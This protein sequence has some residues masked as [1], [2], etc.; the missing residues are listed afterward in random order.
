MSLIQLPSA[1]YERHFRRRELKV[2]IALQFTLLYLSM[3]VAGM[4]GR[5]L[6]PLQHAGVA[7]LD[8]RHATYSRRILRAM[9]DQEQQQEQQP[10]RE[11]SAGEQE[12]MQ[13]HVWHMQR[14]QPFAGQSHDIDHDSSLQDSLQ[15]YFDSWTTWEKRSYLD[16]KSSDLS[17]SG[18]FDS[19]GDF[20]NSLCL[21]LG[22]CRSSV[23]KEVAAGAEESVESAVRRAE[24]GIE[25]DLGSGANTN[26]N[27][28]MGSV[29]IVVSNPDRRLAETIRGESESATTASS[30]ISGQVEQA[31]VGDAGEWGTRALKAKKNN[32]AA[33]AAAAVAAV[34]G[35]GGV[36]R[37]IRKNCNV[38]TGDCYLQWPWYFS[39]AEAIR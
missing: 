29:D 16:K 20:V 26:R 33:A 11:P 38:W 1:D 18:S 13:Q 32:P 5:G 31:R 36:K 14:Q 8:G 25:L 28:E 10:Y 37:A 27:H 9:E 21:Q 30:A 35:G 22:L 17:E 3:A 4:D 24:Q 6:W 15:D 7:R 23:G 2:F 34:A 12:G 39:V 19:R